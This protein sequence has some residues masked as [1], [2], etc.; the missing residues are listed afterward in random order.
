MAAAVRADLVSSGLVFWLL[1]LELFIVQPAL[2]EDVDGAWTAWSKLSTPC[3]KSCGGGTREKIRT[4]TNPKPEDAGRPCKNM[5]GEIADME[6]EKELCN[7]QSC[8]STDPQWNEWSNCSVVCGIGTRNRTAKMT[9]GWNPET[10][11]E[12]QTEECNT[13]N[14]TSCPDP[15]DDA[16]CKLYSVCENIS[17]DTLPMTQC[18]CLDDYK[19]QEDGSCERPR[20]TPPTPRPIPTME[21]EQK[22]VATVISKTASS[23]LIF[24]VTVTLCLFLV[25]RIF[26]IDR[27][28]QMNMEISLLAGHLVLLMPPTTHENEVSSYIVRVRWTCCRAWENCVV[29]F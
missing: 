6:M 23:V 10:D 25:L 28:I 2:T 24:F 12:F 13:W 18:K 11:E 16:N 29:D 4:C 27:V 22:Q 3:T 1:V 5:R 15:C 19:L 14:I 26:T 20:P 17:N 21:A 8:W 9:N 7:L